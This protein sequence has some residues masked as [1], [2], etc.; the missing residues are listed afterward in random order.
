MIVWLS[1]GELNAWLLALCQIYPQAPMFTSRLAAG[2]D[3][4]VFQGQ[5]S[6]YHDL[7]KIGAI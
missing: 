1:Q 6:A 4:P 5:P 2:E 7:I 3:L